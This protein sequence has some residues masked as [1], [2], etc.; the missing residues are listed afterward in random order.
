MEL[1]VALKLNKE[2][3]WECL[4]T[5]YN[6]EE[7]NYDKL[8]RKVMANMIISYYKNNPNMIYE[9]LNDK[10]IDYLAKLVNND[11]DN[12]LT[13]FISLTFLSILNEVTFKYEILDDLNEL[14]EDRIKYYYENKEE[15]EKEKEIIYLAKGLFVAYGALTKKN[16]IN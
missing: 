10:E 7:L 2:Y 9:I 14:I 4:G 16:L 3:F 6:L 1:K 12:E 15:I 5:F 13:Y 8:T 11:E